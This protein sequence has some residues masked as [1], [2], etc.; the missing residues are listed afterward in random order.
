M[1]LF[2]KETSKEFEEADRMQVTAGELAKVCLDGMLT[3]IR[4][5]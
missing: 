5:Q 3:L 4:M 1:V 2:Q